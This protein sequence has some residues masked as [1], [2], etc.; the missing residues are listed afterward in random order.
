MNFIN[1]IFGHTKIGEK[2]FLN[3]SNHIQTIKNIG[4][5]PLSEQYPKMDEEELY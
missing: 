1:K 5:I 3:N 4:G 2:A